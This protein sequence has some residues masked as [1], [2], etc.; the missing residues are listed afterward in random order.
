MAVF[1]D[2]HG[3]AD[4]LQI[5]VTLVWAKIH[6]HGHNPASDANFG[7]AHI[8]ISENYL[9]QLSLGSFLQRSTLMFSVSILISSK[10]SWTR[11]NGC[12]VL[13]SQHLWGSHLHRVRDESWQAHV[14][15]VPVMVHPGQVPSSPSVPSGKLMVVAT[16]GLVAEATD[17]ITFLVNHQKHR[18]SDFT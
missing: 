12:S 11:R 3:G 7:E 9:F 8:W 6:L 4:V 16:G 15:G 5:F 13:C 18:V 17:Y 1:L 2:L 10:A 14:R